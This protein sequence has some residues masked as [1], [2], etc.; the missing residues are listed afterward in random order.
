ML[1][2]RDGDG[3]AFRAIYDRHHRSIARFVAGQHAGL[4]PDRADELAQD[5]F[6]QA[7]RARER[8]EPRAR[9][10]TWLYTIARN[11]A[12]NEVRR[13]EY[14][15]GMERLDR[16]GDE[17]GWLPLERADPAAPEGEAR[18]AGRELEARVRALIHRLPEG[19][20]TALL[21]SRIDEMRYVEIG[22]VLGV[23][24][25]AVKSLVF[26]AT[27]ALKEGLKDHVELD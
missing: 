4:S 25:Q 20:R 9:V 10:S 22:L 17:G 16:A 8:W 11:L 13:F 7:W 27:Q 19:Q 26:R 12:L 6:V 23:S 18:A 5:V 3:E 14:H 2:V 15:G 24:E 21:L 1:R